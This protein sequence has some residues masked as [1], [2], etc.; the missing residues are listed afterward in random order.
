MASWVDVDG[1]IEGLDVNRLFDS[2]FDPVV[3]SEAKMVTSSFRKW[4][5]FSRACCSIADLYLPRALVAVEVCS[6][7]RAAAVL[8]VSPTYLPGHGMEFAPAQGM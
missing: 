8:S 3:C 6:W 7:K 1:G 5:L 4:W 2:S